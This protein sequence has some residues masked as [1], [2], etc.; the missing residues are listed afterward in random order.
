MNPL[1][2]VI[3]RKHHDNSYVGA[4]DGMLVD[5]VRMLSTQKCPAAN[6]RGTN[7]MK[8]N[9]PV[10]FLREMSE[11]VVADDPTLIVVGW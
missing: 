7:C 2:H 6:K 8:R 9:L 3:K 5:S 10:P 11:D 1:E 4:K